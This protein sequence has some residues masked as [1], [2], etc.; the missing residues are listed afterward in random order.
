MTGARS[1][2]GFTLVELLIATALLSLIGAAIL[3]VAQPVQTLVVV[4]PETA[5]VQQRLRLSAATLRRAAGGAGAGV[6]ATGWPGA[7]HHHFAAVLPYRIGAR[8]ADPD[9]GVF[10]RSDAISVIAVPGDAVPARIVAVASSATPALVRVEANCTST[11]GVC[12]FDVGSSV[13]VFDRGGRFWLGTVQ[14]VDDR[15]LA[16]DSRAIDAGVELTARAVAGR[17]LEVVDLGPDGDQ[18]LPAADPKLVVAVSVRLYGV[19]DVRRQIH[20]E[21]HRVQ[22]VR[23][24]EC[25][26]LGDVLRHTWSNDRP[27]GNRT[28][29]R[30]RVS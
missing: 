17:D 4:Q 18:P 23:A 14:R 15:L 25:S 10:F 30:S 3:T 22:S 28:A 9:R 21:D 19:A 6:S 5:D 20:R 13:A 27:D 24:T 26:A 12:G 7:L 16:I 8:S 29:R 2:A 11:L 1:P